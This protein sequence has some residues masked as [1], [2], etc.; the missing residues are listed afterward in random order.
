MKKT[1]KNK[2]LLLDQLTKTPILQIACDKANISRMTLH[3]WKKEDK[4]FSKAID[5][6]LLE[7]KLLV[8]D[9][10]ESQLIGAVKDRNIPA[11]IYWLKNHHQDYTDTVN[12]KHTF[13]VEELT[14][15]QEALVREALR[16]AGSYISNNNKNNYEQQNDTKLFTGASTEISG[17]N[18]K[19]QTD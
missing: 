3:R 4:E 2:K 15:E 7:G 11:I 18:D 12:L 14:P 16:L 17:S 6:A 10:A 19:R 9:L 1:D 8:N 5:D 13:E